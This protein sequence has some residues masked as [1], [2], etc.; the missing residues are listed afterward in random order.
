MTQFDLA[1]L[2]GLRFC[3]SEELHNGWFRHTY[4]FGAVDFVVD[5]RNEEECREEAGRDFFVLLEETMEDYQ[6]RILGPD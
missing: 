6:R 2:M 1:T 4:R 5:A 3:A